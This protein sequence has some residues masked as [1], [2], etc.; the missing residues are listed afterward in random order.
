MLY[1]T[2]YPVNL[3]F[4]RKFWQ[5][6]IKINR[7]DGIKM[8][9]TLA[10]VL[11]LILAVGV[12]AACNQVQP[13]ERKVRWDKNETWTYN[14]SL[15]NFT[16]SLTD[17]NITYN[18]D[19]LATGETS[20]FSGSVDR[21]APNKLTGTYVVSISQ[22]IA[23]DTTTVSTTQTMVASYDANLVDTSR[24]DQSIIVEQTDETVSLKSTQETKVIF[25]NGTQLPVS[26][27]TKA[28]GFY[29]GKQNQSMSNYEISTEYEVKGKKVVAKVTQGDKTEDVT[30]S[31][32]NV[33]D[34][35]Q[36]LMF[37]RSYDKAETSFQDSPQVTVF[38][39][40]TKST[41][42]LSTQYT[43][44]QSVLVEHKFANETESVK[45]ATQMPRVDMK[46][47]GMAF[48]TQVSLPDMTANGLDR[49]ATNVP[50]VYFPMHTIYRFRSGFVSYE[51]A[52]YL[53]DNMVN[54][55][56]VKAA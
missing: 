4:L 56:K 13:T 18:R 41:K 43:A 52:S 50:G 49:I 24:F 39:P 6:A 46:L 22:D 20:P 51:L 25:K 10:L 17:S 29:L 37:I 53:T 19:F 34:T 54:A 23:N 1:Y 16:D 3:R 12:F 48:V 36:V 14:I 7:K 2:K 30:I 15:A 31:N 47:D 21:I 8:K 44:K 32:T 28:N 33:I 9:K 38:D 45:V 26:S 42:I 11:L 35:N 40:L 5:F 55:I 27:Y